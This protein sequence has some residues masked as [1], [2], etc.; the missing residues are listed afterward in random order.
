MMAYTSFDNDQLYS[1]IFSFYDVLISNALLLF[2]ILENFL[3]LIDICMFDLVYST[4]IKG[5]YALYY[6]LLIVMARLDL[7]VVNCIMGFGLNL[8]I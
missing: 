6:L 4:I 1:V 8:L 3:I 5:Y 7:S 2:S